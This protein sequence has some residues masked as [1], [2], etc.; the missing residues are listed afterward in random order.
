VSEGQDGVLAVSTECPSCGA[1]LDFR[2]A[3]NAVRCAHCRSQLLVTGRGQLLAYGIAAS[4]TESE[5]RSLVQ[6]AL[7]A[8]RRGARACEATLYRIPYYRVTAEELL[9]RVDD[10]ER[11]RRRNV[12]E[13]AAWLGRETPKWAEAD[14][15]DVGSP[16]SGRL[17]FK[18]RF[19][20][21][22][23]L[24]RPTPLVP[25]S[26]GVRSEVVRL[27]LFDRAADPEGT[28]V[29]APDPGVAAEPPPP[30]PDVRARQLVRV[31]RQLLWFP[32][33]MVPIESPDGTSIAVVDA[34]AGRIVR[35]DGE[36]ESLRVLEHAQVQAATIG[37]RP[38]VC[39][40]CGWD[41]PL[42]PDDAVFVCRTCARAWLV[43]G[44]RLERVPFR[45]ASA[46]ADTVRYLPV[47]K[48][49]G[50]GTR[51]TFA[52][53]F[54]CRGLRP[55]VEL[56]GRLNAQ[57]AAF[58]S[59]FA[60]GD[61]LAANGGPTAPALLGCALDVADARALAR[62]VC[63]GTESATAPGDAPSAELLWLPFSHDG[64]SLREPRTGAT[65]P[66]RLLEESEADGMS[67]ERDLVSVT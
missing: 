39:P 3:A 56:G 23:F 15:L 26:L 59:N 19:L 22:S 58:P 38:L 60:G 40:N 41:L 45:V 42:R 25:P 34:V 21:R 65:I 46:A 57:G 5:A 33:W 7:P 11:E 55:L 30:G 44:D 61:E 37:F 49:G 20:Q 28:V 52:P 64:Y 1:G 32:F 67:G 53:A 27:V 47:W 4:S 48:L 63:E 54:R 36:A 13:V 35:P 31:V 9:W 24:A 66:R 2:E 8:D 18:S 14:A 6:F 17:A 12:A 43:D 10:P 50:E 16:K 29:V 51:A 62:F